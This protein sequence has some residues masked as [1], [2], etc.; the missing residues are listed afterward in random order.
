[1][2]KQFSGAVRPTTLIAP[3]DATSLAFAIG[4]AASWPD[5]SIAPFVAA[6]DRGTDNE[7]LVVCQSRSAETIVVVPGGRGHDNTIARPHPIGAVVEHVLDAETVDEANRFVNLLANPGDLI[8]HDDTAP[9]VLPPPGASG[10]VLVSDMAA[11]SKLQWAGAGDLNVEL[12]D[13]QVVEVKLATGAVTST[14]IA[15]LAVD[16]SKLATGAVSETRLAAGA[17]TSAKLHS[18]VL[19]ATTA[20]VTGAVDRWSGSLNV[21]RIGNMCWLH[22]QITH[23]DVVVTT[24]FI[25]NLPAALTPN[26]TRIGIAAE[27]GG[28]SSALRAVFAQPFGELVIDNVQRDRTYAISM[29]WMLP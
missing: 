21:Q 4:D 26:S 7:E 5:G 11:P 13:G 18:S 14:K 17:V 8:T 19:A 9:V 24:G 6:I 23:L 16:N 28:G 12:S 29:A 27:S 3:L 15:A 22:G 20:T 10:L 2:R 25:N 1:M